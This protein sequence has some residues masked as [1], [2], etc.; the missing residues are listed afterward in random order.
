MSGCWGPAPVN[1]PE[2]VAPCG[3]RKQNKQTKVWIWGLTDLWTESSLTVLLVQYLLFRTAT[4]RMKVK[5]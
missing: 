5:L 1:S 4:H 2:P 3:L